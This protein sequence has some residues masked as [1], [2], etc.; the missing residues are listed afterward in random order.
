[1]VAR[2]SPVLDQTSVAVTVAPVLRFFR[3]GS[4]AVSSLLTSIRARL[5]AA[6]G[7]VAALTVLCSLV[8]LYAF[9]T[10]GDTTTSIVARNMPATVQSLRLAEDASR[11]LASVPRLMTIEDEKT[12]KALAA[13]ITQHLGTLTGRIENLRMLDSAGSSEVKTIQATM[14][15]R[16]EVLKRLVHDR[17]GLAAERQ[18]LAASIR[19][20][21]D[22]FLGGISPAA[23]DATL[24]LTS[25]SDDP[26]SSKKALDL[27]R[28]LLELKSEANL[29]A[30][31]LSEGAIVI[32]P[33]RVQALIVI[34]EAGKRKIEAQIAALPTE[35]LRETL[36][37]FFG[38]L[39]ALIGDNGIVAIRDQ[40]LKTLEQGHAAFNATQR[41]AL[42]LKLAVDQ[43]VQAQ[44]E[45]TREVSERAADQ[46]R[47]GQVVLIALSI[48]A[49]AAA[50]LIAWLY[51]GRNIARRLGLL[52]GA[53]QKIA[54]GDLA[55]AIP[56]G[57]GDEIAT[58]ART[59]RVFR[60]ATAD[61]T[62]ARQSEAERAREAETKRDEVQQ[63]T[64]NFERAVSEIVEA[65]DRSSQAMD[66]SARSM[67]ETAKRNQ[68]QATAT[69]AASEEAT[70][71]VSDVAMAAEQMAQTIEKIGVQMSESAAMA[72][73]AAG[74]TQNVSA[75]V[76]G[77]AASMDQI[78]EV[79]AL[80]RDIAAQTNLLAL[81]ATIEAAR[82]GDAGRGFAVV[83]QEVKSLAA[84]TE[85]ATENI[86]QQIA[87][88]GATATRAI[89]A[90]KTISE[91]ISR[92]DQNANL[93][94]N[95]IVEQ[96]TVTQHIARSAGAAAEGTQNVSANVEEVSQAATQTEKIADDV[97]RAGNDLSER[98]N[99]LRGEVEKFLQRVRAA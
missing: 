76:E 79:S 81:N 72:R 65:F 73:Q 85:K 86:T 26:V 69:A 38:G 94:A 70:R 98:S 21:R 46:I 30:G 96:G 66:A 12:E 1:M 95:A 37:K 58:M 49:L 43:L 28:R 93:V 11:L 18:K 40:E 53:M 88:I 41:E 47:S 10:I 14:F 51:V 97:L 62:T 84:Q 15:E 25:F 78:G 83:A 52:S 80:I 42:S 77:L 56:D 33:T 60:Q 4:L 19:Q 82:A 59:L 32:D 57:G 45:N 63:A 16:I 68:G 6:F 2:A 55:A 36:T 54:D 87:S 5:Y 89:E 34:T 24:A 29:L 3:T 48:A 90:M 75:A 39:A 17:I 92:L 91:T 64:R 61:V 99:M 44:S 13:E 7:F 8:G 74:E 35:D 22:Q 9:T 50:I 20:A 31:L 71:N 23:D 27:L 67:A